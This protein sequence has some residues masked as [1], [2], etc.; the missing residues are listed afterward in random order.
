MFG[1]CSSRVG[2]SRRG[3]NLPD[4]REAQLAFAAHI[5]NPELNPAPADVESRRM[6]IYVD[7]FYNNI[8]NFLAQGFPIAKKVLGETSWHGLVRE[9]VDRHPSSSPY[10]LEISQ[11]F[12]AFLGG[13]AGD[14]LP[15]FLLELCHYEWVELALSVTETELPTGGFDPEGDLLSNPVLVSPL[16]WCLAY[17]WP[18]HEIGPDH[19]PEV[20]P[21]Q[22]TELIVYRRRDDTVRFMVV[23]PVTLALVERLK[24]GLTGREALEAVARELAGVDSNVI[25]EQGIATLERLRDAQVLLGVTFEAETGS[26]EVEAD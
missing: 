24:T 1:R 12:L 4:F 18:V 13:R 26:E 16:T 23:N 8:Q 7:L 9:F 2:M 20:P 15:P 17:R 21:E 5:R 19:M 14:D 22:A 25:Y 6:K 3:S 10:F 11:E